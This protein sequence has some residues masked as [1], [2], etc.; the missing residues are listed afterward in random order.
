[1]ADN[2][3]DRTSSSNHSIRDEIRDY[4]SSRAETFDQQPG[5]EIFSEKE[6]QAW[7]KLFSHHL[8]DAKGRKALDLAC[9]T[10]VIS[11]L[12][13]DLGFQTTGLDW[14]EQMLA[15]A[16][17]KSKTRKS[18]IQFLQ[19]DAEDTR[20]PE[21]SYDI[22]IMR[23][24]VWTL[25]DPPVAFTH[26]YTLLKPGGKI[27]IVDGDFVNKNWFSKLIGWIQKIANPF[28]KPTIP[29]DRKRHLEILAQVY[30]K[31]GARAESIAQLLKEAGFVALRI[32]SDL[33]KINR[34]QGKAL[35]LMKFLS[36]TAQHRYAIYA[37]KPSQD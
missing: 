8:G 17:E 23:H 1:M 12:M 26:W 11:H 18:S 33:S 35:G 7:L 29:I 16:R 14:S 24:L 3:A 10:G 25:V 20:E 19:A 37:E 34:A 6:R 31:D 5:H 21:S 22:I 4:W 36:R 9:G 28:A 32:Q 30:F 27:L 2:P 13:H 15:K